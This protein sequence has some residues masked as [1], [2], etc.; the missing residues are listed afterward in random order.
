MEE[1][2]VTVQRLTSADDAQQAYCCMTEV[3]S[4]WPQALCQC[5]EWVAHNLGKHI[6]GFHVQLESGEVAG[7]LYYAFSEKALIPY[8]I[9]ES[10]GVL[11]CEWVQ[12]RYQGKGLGRHLF[13]AFR[14]EMERQAVKGILVENTETDGEGNLK[15]YL[16]LGFKVVFESDRGRLLYLPIDQGEVKVLP[17]KARIVPRQ[18]VPVEILVIGGYMCPYEAATLLLLQEVSREFG[19]RVALQQ[20]PLTKETLGEYGVAKGIFING[21]PSLSGAETEESI[22]QA[23]QEAL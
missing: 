16:G 11:Y 23:I 22:R 5:R 7:H 1:L 17:L 4:P 12:R 2:K 19:D 9:E 13:A 21:R 6:E 15:R 8:E 20:V 10:V 3:P 14:D 18:G